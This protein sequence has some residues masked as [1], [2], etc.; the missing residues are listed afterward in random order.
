MSLQSGKKWDNCSKFIEFY[1]KEATNVTL[2]G[3]KKAGCLAI[4]Q[5]FLAI[6]H[7][8]KVGETGWQ[9]W[10]FLPTVESYLS[11]PFGSL[12]RNPACQPAKCVPAYMNSVVIST[13]KHEETAE[14]NLCPC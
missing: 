11:S 4:H 5:F 7:E 10:I 13:G 6:F 9:F 3:E 14:E 2:N 8:Q 1:V 12:L